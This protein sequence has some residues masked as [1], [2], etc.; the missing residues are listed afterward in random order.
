MNDENRLVIMRVIIMQEE[1]V[2]FEADPKVNNPPLLLLLLLC[3]ALSGE[4]ERG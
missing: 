1:E 2:G 4:D 3:T